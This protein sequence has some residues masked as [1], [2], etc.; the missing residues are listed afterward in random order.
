VFSIASSDLFFDPLSNELAAKVHNQSRA[1]GQATVEFSEGWSAQDAQRFA[2]VESSVAGPGGVGFARVSS[3]EWAL[4]E[5]GH[6]RPI[7]ATLKPLSVD[8]YGV[9]RPQ[10]QTVY[11]LVCSPLEAIV[12]DFEYSESPM[13]RGWMALPDQTATGDVTTAYDQELG[14]RVM[15]IR[16]DADEGFVIARWMRVYDRPKLTLWIESTHGFIVYV[17]VRNLDGESYYVQYMPWAWPSSPQEFPEGRYVY[18]PLG[19]YSADGRWH[20]LERDVYEDFFVKTGMEVAFIDGLS[21]R[22]Y[23]D[24]GVADLRLEVRK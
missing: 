14:K 21:V 13:A 5:A 23:D 4:L 22:A 24:V 12:D 8:T 10:P 9:V 1:P 3:I 17:A 7:W 11:N 18:Y 20:R 6:C 2:T 15:R 19:A 16:T